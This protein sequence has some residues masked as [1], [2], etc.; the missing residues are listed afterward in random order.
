MKKIFSKLRAAAQK[1]FTLV[2]FV[3][4]LAIFSVMAGIALFNFSGFE[5]NISLTNLAHDIAL[6]IRQ[7]QVFGISATESSLGFA[8]SKTRGVYFQ[9]DGS[10]FLKTFIIFADEQG[11]DHQFD[12]NDDQIIDEITVSSS[13][14]ISGIE[15]GP[16]AN[17]LRSLN[18]DLHI[19]FTRPKPEAWIISGGARENYAIIAIESVSGQ[20]RKIEVFKSGQIRVTQ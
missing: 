7:A 11:N 19:T 20:E 12:P 18:D 16:D 15:V 1:G 2:E 6:T 3:V 13:D 4:I 14:S 5:S 17:N 10:E 8:P 9:Y